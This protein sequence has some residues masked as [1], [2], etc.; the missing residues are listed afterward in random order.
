MFSVLLA[1]GIAIWFAL[2]CP[3]AI[4]HLAVPRPAE[5]VPLLLPLALVAVFAFMPL[6]FVIPREDGSAVLQEGLTASNIVT[7]VLT[8]LTA[9]YLA[10]R[11][12]H[13]PTVAL[14]PLAAAYLPFTLMI[15]FDF[16]SA[17]WSIVPAYTVYRAF[18]LAIFTTASILIFDRDDLASSLRGIL[19]AFILIWLAAVAPIIVASLVGGIVFSA[20]KNNMMPLVCAALMLLV[21]FA[22][23]ARYRKSSFALG[24]VGFVIAG[25]A[26]SA[27]A[28][29][30][31]LGPALLIAS[32]RP[33]RRLLGWVAAA[34]VVSGF[35]TLMVGLSSVP[36]LV[37]LL[38]VVLQKP[39]VELAN[40]TGRT[41]FW[42]TFIAATRDHVFGSGFSAADRFV[43]LLI[44][45]SE[46][47]DT[48]GKDKIFIT[49]S[50]NMFLS[51]W[52][53]TG[54]AGLG[55]AAVV[56]GGAVRQGLRLEL[57]G[58]RFVVSAVLMLILNG[59]TTPGIFQDWTV[60]TFA[61]V[62]VLAYGRIGTLRHSLVRAARRDQDPERGF[63]APPRW[64][65]V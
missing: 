31:A 48:L 11:I 49:S 5:N 43:Q 16:T 22:P 57:G 52:A 47:A 35:L 46:L 10:F 61:F 58:R 21:A 19:V 13:R 28:L 32:S 24:F 26:A 37:D 60:N 23:P 8:G 62:A 7:L 9:L 55:F 3:L 59:M 33:A 18:E 53:G 25:S 38:S 41:T 6:V 17:I 44:P 63:A 64:S 12:A 27:G 36:G 20:A 1:V 54:V 14:L 30:A 4:R 39:A 51:A 50:H 15:M 40:A 2:L 29:L 42:P 45:T 56:L 65:A 34:L